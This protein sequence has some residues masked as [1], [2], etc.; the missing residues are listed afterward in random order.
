M[1][2]SK[3][4]FTLFKRFIPTEEQRAA[5]E[6]A[7]N[8][9]CRTNKEQRVAIV[10]LSFPRPVK[11]DLL[12][13]IEESV[14]KA[15]D[16]NGVFLMPSYP[17]ECFTKEY[18]PEIVKEA[19]RTG[20]VGRGFLDDY[21]VEFGGEEIRLYLPWNEGGMSFLERGR[22]SEVFEKIIKNEFSLVRSVR[23]LQNAAQTRGNEDFLAG[24]RKLIEEMYKGGFAQP[25]PE[26][27]KSGKGKKE[28]SDEAEEE[29][30]PA[31]TVIKGTAHP[32]S[33]VAP[34]IFRTGNLTVD[35][36]NPELIYGEDKPEIDEITAISLL[37]RPLSGV[38]ALGQVDSFESRLNKTETKIILI[39][40]LTDYQSS[41]TVKLT[42]DNDETGQALV[43]RFTSASRT[44]KRG[45]QVMVT[46]YNLTLA[47]TGNVKRDRFE[48]D[49]LVLDAKSLCTVRRV[50]RKDDAPVKRV[51]LHL[52]TNLSTMDALT[53][54]E[55]LVDTVLDWEWD[56]F[57]VTDHGNVQSY[58]LLLDC[59][60]KMKDA[61]LKVLYGM[62]AYFVDDTARAAYG[63]AEG[64]I[65]DTEFV[66]F[67]IETTGLSAANCAITEIGA[68]KYKGGKMGE[69]FKTF[70]DP[71]E[72]IPEAIT[73][74]TGITDDMVAGAPGQK[75]A[76]E[77]FLEF[78]GDDILVAH[79]ANF[80]T[81]FI[82][83]VC[84]DY[85]MP[86]LNAYIDTV[87]LSKYVNPD[88]KKHK[89][90]ILAEHYHL[91][92][93]DHHRA[94]E[95]AQ[96]LAMIFDKMCRQLKREGVIRVE[97][98][99]SAMSDRADPKKLP[100]YHMILYAKNLTGLKNLYKL[101]SMSYLDFYHRV[102]RV[103]KTVLDNYREGLIV[104]S[105]CEAGQLYRAI[106]E[107][108]PVDTIKEIASYYDYLEI[109]PLS[110]NRF[111]IANGKVSSDEELMDINRR[112][113]KLGEELN[114]PVVATCD[115]HF[116]EKSDEIYRQI[117]QKGM[118]FQDA[119]RESGLYL[120]TTGEMLEEFSYLG[121][122]KAY[123]VVVTNTRAIADSIER[124]RPIPKGT[125][126]PKMEGAEED[127]QRMCRER[128]K[129]LYEHNGVLPPQV[130][131]RLEKE[132]SSIITHG[133]AVLYIIAQKLVKYSE[134]EGYLV[135]SRGSVG[136]SFVATMA[137]ISEVNPLPPHYRCPKCRYSRF[138]E[139]GS[140]GSGFDLPDAKCPECGAK[141]AQDGQ[142]IPFET[143]L[144]FHGDKS[145]DIDLNFS[146]EVQGRV[147]KYTEDLFGHENVFKAGT[148]GTLA[149]KT[150]YGYVMKYLD[151]K[152]VSVNRAEVNRLVNGCVGVKRTTGQHPGG[153]V[154]IP[155][156]YDVYDFTPVQHPADD[157]TS[158]IVTT[159]FPFA[160]L[161]DTILKLDELGH[162]V[163]TKYKWL[164]KYSGMSVLDVPMNAPEVY[165]LFTSVRPLGL[166][167]GEID[168]DIGTYGLP[169]LGTR[170]AQRML[171]EAQPKSFADMLQ[172]SG[173]SHGTDVWTGNAQ[174]LIKNG[175]CTI[176]DVVGTRD[177]I[178]LTLI[179]YGLPSEEA[180]GIME[181]VRKGKGLKPDWE[182]HMREHSVP[183]WYIGSC[184]KI[185]YMFPKAH[186]AAY[187]MSAVRLAWFKIHKP[188][189]FY[190]AYFSVAPDG[191]DGQIVAGGRERIRAEMKAISDRIANK[192]DNQK[193]RD[194]QSAMQL[195]LESMARGISYLPVDLYK[196]DA[197]RFLPED[198]KIRM[199]FNC[200]PGLGETAA[201]KIAQARE[202]GGEFFSKLELQERAKL[203]KA[204]MEMLESNHV[205]DGLSETNQI[206]LLQ[207]LEGAP[208]AKKAAKTTKTQASE[209]PAATEDSAAQIS[210]F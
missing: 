107:K 198:G 116:L 148:L 166:S 194:T 180:F 30:L 140:V 63:T 145:P 171:D 61:N 58:P 52:H 188:L 71:G 76:V 106:L 83:K 93:F 162:D 114:K 128:A 135:G 184:K 49:E 151:E 69:I 182:A 108:Q 193:D 64:E 160:F 94:F 50:K 101:V 189:V 118:K 6:K 129:E 98:I 97:Q 209:T 147:H 110:N 161:H 18:F 24:Q 21:T 41:I 136:S 87:P 183:D 54:P 130:S 186:A 137:G 113:C 111:L 55:F 122:E 207:G 36:S 138:V 62:E 72:H 117:L 191:F 96:M 2:N 8:I 142:D 120:R 100:V 1:E 57:G 109:Q 125:Y 48:K 85:R 67:D 86:F 181:S 15:Y 75:E 4:F 10:Q 46:V 20:V 157:P 80:D 7:E 179:R 167:K 29:K 197:K 146:G 25:I 82:R 59:L 16:L 206:G 42:V 112:I 139:D 19:K 126:T 99:A 174:D 70:V 95:D 195:V 187:V 190:A 89:L 31:V 90:D 178:M 127:L 205:L 143:F 3:D 153:I 5:L 164:E 28:E 91:G 60:D 124:I 103:P 14:R 155:K 43:K 81:G 73:E 192:T 45:V 134:S 92:D 44:I 102:P 123:E 131:E 119:D 27:K 65:A 104:G 34:G 196:S 32:A 53:I 47:V 185:K 17:P 175:T 12:Y 163:P 9:V 158:D 84:E 141:L 154:V 203:T 79:N 121:A 150:A 56:T 149:S 200:L 176:S 13:E 152:G 77:A 51:E 38:T 159:H 201:E 133:F 105:A 208:S 35:V 204:V 66:V 170:F 74:L 26:E 33:R 115:S 168:T 144:G 173:L 165:E 39:I 78:A 172:I 22:L 210:L 68:V 23:I 156:E 199:P 177:S 202:E 169:E 37:D 132:L 40:G 88:L 11:K